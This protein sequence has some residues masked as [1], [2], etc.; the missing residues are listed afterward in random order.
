LTR[1]LEISR[2][3][4]SGTP[5]ARTINTQWHPQYRLPTQIAE[6]GR[7]TSFNYD[8][9]GNLLTKTIAANGNNRT[10]TYTYN[11]NGQITT[12]TGPRTDVVDLTTYA[13]D[14]SGNLASITNAL[15]QITTFSNYDANGRV[16]L[17]TD[18]NGA[19]TTLSYSLRGWLTSKVVTAG[20]IVQTTSYS[21]DK[22]GQLVQV[23]LPDN[24]TM[25]YTYDPAH[26]LTN[27]KDSLG[28]SINYTLDLM[29]N[30][31]GETVTDPNGVL[32][33]QV[34]RVYDSLNRIQQVVGAEQ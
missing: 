9:N 33:S 15:N 5:L 1:D 10:W 21:Y 3:E 28:N 7:T 24:T 26:R 27:I 8:N 34:S 32:T 19:T 11:T 4:A 30:R 13:Y 18:P 17:I 31:V 6:P 29:S 16:G 14:G 20:N 2:T 25:A 22:T 12:I 23:T